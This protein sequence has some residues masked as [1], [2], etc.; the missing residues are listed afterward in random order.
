MKDKKLNNNKVLNEDFYMQ[1][2]K[3]ELTDIIAMFYNFFLWDI[4]YEEMSDESFKNSTN[5]LYKTDTEKKQ[6][7]IEHR[8]KRREDIK[9]MVLEA[10]T[11][12]ESRKFNFAKSRNADYILELNLI[13]STDKKAEDYYTTEK[14]IND[15]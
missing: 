4:K 6:S 3:E 11:N 14:K 7:I 9:N 15:K 2:D 5:I 13:R 10:Y 12:G 1:T 8:N